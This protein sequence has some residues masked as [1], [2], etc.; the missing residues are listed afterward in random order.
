M[1]KDTRDLILAFGWLNVAMLVVYV[2]S[3]VVGVIE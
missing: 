1:S 2:M 3:L